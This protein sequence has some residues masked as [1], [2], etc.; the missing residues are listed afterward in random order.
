MAYFCFQ[1]LEELSHHKKKNDKSD[2][3]YKITLFTFWTTVS[4]GP[5]FMSKDKQM[6]WALPASWLSAWFMFWIMV[7]GRVSQIETIASL[8]W[9]QI[10]IKTIEEKNLWDSVPERE[11]LGG[12]RVLEICRG[13]TKSFCS[14]NSGW[15]PDCVFADQDS[16]KPGGESSEVTNNQRMHRAETNLISY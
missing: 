7:H 4:A 3:M 1:L 11:Q 16:I 2:K 13:L 9:K 10:R 5:W 14:S 8:K 12:E 15:T 6:K